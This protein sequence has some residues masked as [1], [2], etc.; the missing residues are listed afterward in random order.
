MTGSHFLKL[1]NNIDKVIEDIKD[2]EFTV[3]IVNDCSTK[4]PKII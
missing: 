2:V 1:L 3:L 4:N